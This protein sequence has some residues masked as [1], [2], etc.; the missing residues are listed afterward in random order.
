VKLLTKLAVVT[1]VSPGVLT[2]T[3]IRTPTLLTQRTIL[4]G[5]G[6]AAGFAVLGDGGQVD[7]DVGVDVE[8]LAVHHQPSEATHQAVFH[9]GLAH[10]LTV[11]KPNILT[12]C[13]TETQFYKHL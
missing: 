7:G 13:I 11:K 12:F 6:V 1:Q 5:I 9:V 4:T 3:H 10:Q 8:D 2:L